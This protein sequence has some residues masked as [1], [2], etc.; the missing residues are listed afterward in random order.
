MKN[1][2]RGSAMLLASLGLAGCMTVGHKFDPEQVNRLQPGTSTISQATTLLGPP[3]AIS[4]FPNGTRLLQWQYVQG[5]L[6]GG[7]GAHVA[8]LFDES[9]RMVRVTHMSQTAVN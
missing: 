2:I 4:S 1:F 9:G 8:V 3:S 7:S 6:G 5:T